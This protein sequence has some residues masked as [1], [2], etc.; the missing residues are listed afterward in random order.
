MSRPPRRVVRRVPIRGGVTPWTRADTLWNMSY[1]QDPY[2]QQPQYPP[3]G[4][5]PGPGGQGPYGQPQY[6]QQPYHPQQPYGAPQPGPYGYGPPPVPPP[7][8]QKSGGALVAG[9][10]IAVVVLAALGAGAYFVLTGGEDET[11]PQS[12][13]AEEDEEEAEEAN[14]LAHPEAENLTEGMGP[15]EAETPGYIPISSDEDLWVPVPEGWEQ[16]DIPSDTSRSGWQKQNQDGTSVFFA[17]ADTEQRGTSDT[18]FLD[19]EGAFEEHLAQY[20]EVQEDIAEFTQDGEPT[21]EHYLIDGRAAYLVQVDQHWTTDNNGESVDAVAG[22]GFLKVE[23][24]D[25]PAAVCTFS[26]WD[27]EEFKTETIDLLLS[28]R[29]V[30]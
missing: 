29:V 12:D 25:L 24:G 5:Q 19:Y 2:G 22:W 7:P 18:D 11:P 8:P 17:C 27:S 16:F 20:T 13:T 4:P 10:L 1:P 9:I 6:G 21:F 14:P 30:A 15:F 28:V 26:S 23:R 3:P